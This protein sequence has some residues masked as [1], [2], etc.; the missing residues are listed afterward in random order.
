MPWDILVAVGSPDYTDRSVAEAALGDPSTS[1]AALQ[2]IAYRHPGLRPRVAVHPAVYPD[3]LAWLHDL[4]DPAVDAALAASSPPPSPTATQPTL[5]AAAPA[6]LRVGL[7]AAVVIAAVVV[8]LAGG[9]TAFAALTGWGPFASGPGTPGA[10]TA[11]ALTVSGGAPDAGQASWRYGAVSTWT[12][13]A[14][15]VPLGDDP[16]LERAV[17]WFGQVPSI[18]QSGPPL[19]WQVGNVWL[20]SIVA[21]YDEGD[22]PNIGVAAFDAATGKYLWS[23]MSHFYQS[24]EQASIQC[25]TVLIGG[26]ILCAYEGEPVAYDAMTGKKKDFPVKISD[27]MVGAMTAHGDSVYMLTVGATTHLVDIGSNGSAVWDQELPATV[28]PGCD[29]GTDWWGDVQ[30]AGSSALVTSQ[31]SNWVVDANGQVIT[32]FCGGE[33]TADAKGDIAVWSAAYNFDSGPQ[34]PPP[35]YTDAGGA[36][37]SITAPTGV[38]DYM[39]AFLP[40]DKAFATTHMGATMGLGVPGGDFLWTA[41]GEFM[42]TSDEHVIMAWNPTP[43]GRE[44]IYYGIDSDSGKTVW[45][46]TSANDTE[47]EVLD[48]HGRGVFLVDDGSAYS[49]AD[50]RTGNVLWQNRLPPKGPADDDSADLREVPGADAAGGPVMITSSASL[51]RLDPAPVAQAAD[52]SMR[53]PAGMPS[54]PSGMQPVSWTK[55]DTGSILVCHGTTYQVILSDTG[56]PAVAAT[57]LSF[58]PAGMTITCSDGMVYRIGG[59]GS[60]VIVDS[61]GNSAVHAATQAWTPAGGQVAYQAAPSGI[62]P[63]PAGTWPISLST[64]DSGWLLVCGTD[65]ATPAWLG[66]SDGASQGT[67]TAVTATSSGYCADTDAGKACANSA[68][69]LVTVT[70]PGGKTTQHPVSSNFFPSTGAGGTGQGTG[71]YGVN[72]PDNTAADEA[73][74]IEQVLKASAKTRSDLKA[75]LAHLNE[76]TASDEDIATLR[77]VVD[78][79]NQLIEAM[80][81]APVTKLPNGA[82]LVS[83]LREALVVSEQADELYVTWAQ[84][85]QAQ[86]WDAAHATIQQ[87]RDPANRSESLKKDFVD[88][89]NKQVAPAYDVST[90][91][92]SQV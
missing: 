40:G 73:R 86:D 37:H 89:W 91:K 41:D 69:A 55:Y 56:H 8:V 22:G 68:P 28:T 46:R 87:W 90:F 79:R 75:V 61:D 32:T 44:S 43:D 38:I 1:A 72:A 27:D 66:F 45:T 11:G 42:A 80:D 60:V 76:N 92:A 64:W 15:K 26:D 85:I 35:T 82:E 17:W 51:T 63:C 18:G 30:V 84:Q 54:C 83:A 47:G 12:A 6:K 16:A 53:P 70:P 25:A 3:L 57:S 20:A 31:F 59:G 13:S 39:I 23:D 4:H 62:V 52:K 77:S 24:S 34:D 48:D 67:S 21:E 58:S 19:V 74:Y 65:S 10:G 71:A 33:A 2:Q 5:P 78:S 7:R 36:T 14:E 88:I 49:A 29:P 50:P 9:G 81:G